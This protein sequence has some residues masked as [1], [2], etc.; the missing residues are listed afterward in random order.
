VGTSV[1]AF[2]ADPLLGPQKLRP[3]Q[4]AEDDQNHL[5]PAAA[6]DEP[7]INKSRGFLNALGFWSPHT[8]S[9]L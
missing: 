2:D 8:E 3:S 9:F 5:N 4:Q 1:P 6:Q 7:I